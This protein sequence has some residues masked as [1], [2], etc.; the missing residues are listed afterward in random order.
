AGRFRE[1]ADEYR[2]ELAIYEKLAAAFPAEPDYRYHQARSANFLGI[3]L[4][5]HLTKDLEAAVSHHRKAV[6]LCDQLVTQFPDRPRYRQQL[7]RSHYALGLALGKTGR[8]TEV[9]ACFRLALAESASLP[10]DLGNLQH[11]QPRPAP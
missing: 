9:E 5:R 3:A 6:K 2:Q 7:V 11:P 8:W 4:R 1:A 10:D